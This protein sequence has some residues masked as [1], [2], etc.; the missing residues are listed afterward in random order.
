MRISP[1]QPLGD[2]MV[3]DYIIR[4]EEQSNDPSSTA[5]WCRERKGAIAAPE[6]ASLTSRV[7]QAPEE[8]QDR[9]RAL[10]EQIARARYPLNLPEIADAILEGRM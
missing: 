8:R 9:V 4:D 5:F 6:L 7:L 3:Q 10:R 2:S 1:T